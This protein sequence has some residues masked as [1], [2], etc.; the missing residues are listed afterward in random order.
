[1]ALSKF[2]KNR[3]EH[4]RRLISLLSN[5]YQYVSILGIDTKATQIIANRAQNVIEH[6]HD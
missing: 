6:S 1:M 5:D 3:K 2:L 4:A